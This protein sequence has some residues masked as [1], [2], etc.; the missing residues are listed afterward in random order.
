M[1]AFSDFCDLLIVEEE[2]EM[3]EGADGPGSKARGRLRPL[4]PTLDPVISADWVLA[5][6]HHRHKVDGLLDGHL[7]PLE[8]FEEEQYWIAITSMCGRWQ[9]I[10]DGPRA[11]WAGSDAVLGI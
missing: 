5:R 2:C 11:Y 3:H 6:Q 4:P 7:N 9:A 10:I 8:F 1:E